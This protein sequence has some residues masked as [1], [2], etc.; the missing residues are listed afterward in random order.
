MSLRFPA[1]KGIVQVLIILML[2][3]SIGENG[4]IMADTAKHKFV[5]DKGFISDAVT[6][7]RVA[8]AILA[9][10]YGEEKINS[11]KPFSASLQNSVWIIR[12]HLP[13]GLKG[14]V[15]EIEISQNNACVLRVSHGK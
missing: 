3:N 14:G 11:E 2:L 13:E 9:P 8:E 6:A 12:G 4:P 15:A 1:I 5:P 10:I 7:I